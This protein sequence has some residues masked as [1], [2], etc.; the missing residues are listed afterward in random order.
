[1]VKRL[2]TYS[3]DSEVVN[4]LNKYIDGK[5]NKSLL[6]ESLIIAWVNIRKEEELK[7][8]IINNVSDAEKNSA[9]IIDEYE[10]EDLEGGFE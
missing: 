8:N 5:K 3:I 10:G 2:C 9:V 6:I 7:D 1:M 4:D